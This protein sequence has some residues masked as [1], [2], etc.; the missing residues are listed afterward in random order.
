MSRRIK[1]HIDSPLAM[2]VAL[3]VLAGLAACE[4]KQA[5]AGTLAEP[6]TLPYDLDTPNLTLKLAKA[7]TEVSGIAVHADRTS[8]WAVD[9]EK[10]TL[11]R[12]NLRTGKITEK[13]KFAKRGDYEGIEVV[14]TSVVIARSDGRLSRIGPKKT[15]NY[16]SPVSKTCDVEGLALDSSRD[17]L[18][19]ACKG[20]SG[21]RADKHQRLIY[22]VGLPNYKWQ[23]KPAYV[24]SHDRL[25][26]FIKTHKTKGVRPKQAKDF[27]PSAIAVQPGTGYIYLLSSRGR[28][29]VVLDGSTGQILSVVALRRRVHAQPEG[30]S[31]DAKGSMYLTNEGRSGR[32]VL[33]RFDRLH[34]ADKEITP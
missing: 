4:A 10:G 17:R 13:R 7:L 32:A 11:F 19:V 9:D 28:A 25:R 6:L 18:L 2:A 22:A 27:S 15:R 31:F 26:T 20:V 29:L 24:L 16:D 14:G 23:S 34:G 30:L 1:D 21:P 3:I 5:T 12:V 33:H 8:A